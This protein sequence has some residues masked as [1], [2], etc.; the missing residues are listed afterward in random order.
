MLAAPGAAGRA[1]AG[2]HFVENEKHL[3]LVA[4]FAQLL[5]PFAAEMIIAALAL[6]RLDDDGANVGAAFRNR[7]SNFLLRIFFRAR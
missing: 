5:Q 7:L 6:D 1:H 4:D 2:L 3:V